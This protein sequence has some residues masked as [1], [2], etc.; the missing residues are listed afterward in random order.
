MTKFFSFFIQNEK[1]LNFI[2]KIPNKNHF[3]YIS[4]P[5]KF[6]SFS[7]IFCLGCLEIGSVAESAAAASLEILLSLVWGVFLMG[8]LLKL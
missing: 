5:F 3:P 2:I 4:K 8:P 7:P 1:S 6:F